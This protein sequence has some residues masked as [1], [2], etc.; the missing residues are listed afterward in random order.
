MASA[1]S[2]VFGEPHSAGIHGAAIICP[3]RRRMAVR[4][5]GT[6]G[7]DLLKW[8]RMMATE[9]AHI[10]FGAV[11]VRERDQVHVSK[12][13]YLNGV[14]PMQCGL[15]CSGSSGWRRA[16]PPGDAAG[17]TGGP[18]I[19]RVCPVRVPPATTHHV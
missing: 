7:P 11:K 9:W 12:R 1:D 19:L 3:L 8:R 10:R 13:G 15:K 5:S 6:F 14:D 17:R 16:V 4:A 2:V 18:F